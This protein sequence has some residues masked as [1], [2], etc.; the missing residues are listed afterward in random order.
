[1]ESGELGASL[2]VALT[3]P[4][5]RFMVGTSISPL[6]SL[7]VIVYNG[8]A[9]YWSMVIHIRESNINSSRCLMTEKNIRHFLTE[10]FLISIIFS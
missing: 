2:S 1:M 8:R 10:Q 6:V 3:E 5:T 9:E 7:I 4:M